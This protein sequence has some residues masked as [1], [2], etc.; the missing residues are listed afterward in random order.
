MRHAIT[1]A[2]KVAV[3]L[4]KPLVPIPAIS[5]HRQQYSLSASTGHR[6][7][8]ISGHIDGLELCKMKSA[9]LR[10]GGVGVHVILSSWGWSMLTT[11]I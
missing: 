9:R 5:L 8:F 3:P 4:V 6:I 1:I 10:Q 2:R 7:A 11:R